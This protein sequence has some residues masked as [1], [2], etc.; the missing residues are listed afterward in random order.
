MKRTIT[1]IKLSD[2]LNKNVVR[3]ESLPCQ[4]DIQKNTFQRELLSIITDNPEMMHCGS[5]RFESL[6][7]FFKDNKWIIEMEAVEQP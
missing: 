6:K 2:G 7:M 3:F 4:S 5:S 1:K